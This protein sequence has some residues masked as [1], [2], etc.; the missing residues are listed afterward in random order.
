[1][2]VSV[3]TLV[4][5]RLVGRQSL[6]TCYGYQPFYF[7]GRVWFFEPVDSTVS[8]HK[9]SRFNQNNH[10]AWV[11]KNGKAHLLWQRYSTIPICQFAQAPFIKHKQSD[12][13][14]LI[15]I[16]V[17]QYVNQN[18]F[19]IVHCDSCGLG[20]VTTL[21]FHHQH[22][23]HRNKPRGYYSAKRR[24]KPEFELNVWFTIKQHR[25]RWV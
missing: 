4:Y 13:L 20:H 14:E 15:L 10:N 9:H 2:Y 12:L 6:F 19:Y 22:G 24:C 7:I 8:L 21:A 16:D 23:K 25:W 1:M 17:N 3:L 18:Y 11:T 5:L